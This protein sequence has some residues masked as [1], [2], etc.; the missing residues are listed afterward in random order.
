MY[1]V[2]P[3]LQLAIVSAGLSVK[4]ALVAGTA[5]A[6]DALAQP[7]WGRIVPGAVA[8]YLVVNG[9]KAL[10]PLYS[11]GQASLRELVIGG[12]SVWRSEG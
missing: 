7:T 12:Q 3:A 1:G 10:T 11:W 8:D 9:E 5:N 6:A 4:E 2:L